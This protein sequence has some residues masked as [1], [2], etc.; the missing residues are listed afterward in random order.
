MSWYLYTLQAVSRLECDTS[1]QQN[2]GTY[3]GE[4]IFLKRVH[5]KHTAQEFIQAR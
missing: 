3:L 1:Q 4:L 5:M 2:R